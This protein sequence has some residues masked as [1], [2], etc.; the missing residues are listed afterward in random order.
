MIRYRV[1][2]RAQNQQF[3]FP[4]FAKSVFGFVVKQIILLRVLGLVA[5]LLAR[6]DPFSGMGNKW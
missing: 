6:L 1:A 2:T 5:M 4:E 3:T